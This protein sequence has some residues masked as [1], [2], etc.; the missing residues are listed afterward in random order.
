MEL[1]SAEGASTRFLGLTQRYRRRGLSSGGA[2]R[3]ALPTGDGGGGGGALLPAPS[4]G[5][6]L[7]RCE[8]LARGLA[9]QQEPPRCSRLPQAAAGGVGG[10]G[11]ASFSRFRSAFSV[12]LVQADRTGISLKLR[13]C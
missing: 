8:A 6:R 7:P 3:G 4:G 1:S 13:D 5:W 9:E 2:G 11:R 10:V 12:V